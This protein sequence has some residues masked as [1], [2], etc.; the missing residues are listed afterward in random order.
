M[1]AGDDEKRGTLFP[2]TD[3]DGVPRVL[4]GGRFDIGA[5]E[6]DWRKDYSKTLG[7]RVEVT[8]V[9]SNVV[10]AVGAVRVPEGTLS[11]EWQVRTGSNPTF[12]A[13]VTGEGVLSIVL[14]GNAFASLDSGDGAQTFTLPADVGTRVLDFQYSGDGYAELSGFS[15]NAG[16]V[17]FLR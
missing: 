9:T 2:E 5:Y 14:D 1:D 16:S 3:L 11:L 13:S 10:E 12:N 4:N 17:I 8:D 6:Y 15:G 7:K